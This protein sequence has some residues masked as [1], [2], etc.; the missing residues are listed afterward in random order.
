MSRVAQPNAICPDEN[1]LVCLENQIGDEIILQSEKSA[2][3]ADYSV[4]VLNEHERNNARREK[5]YWR[6]LKEGEVLPRG[7]KHY[8]T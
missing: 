1:Y 8:L 6:S 7:R 2:D 5:Y 4:E 3:R